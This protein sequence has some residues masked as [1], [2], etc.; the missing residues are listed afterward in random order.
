MNLTDEQWEVLEPPLLPEPPHQAD[1]RSGLSLRS[2]N[3]AL[4]KIMCLIVA[5]VVILALATDGAYAKAEAGQRGGGGGVR[6]VPSGGG[7][8]SSPSNR[9]SE[10]APSSAEAAK[11]SGPSNSYSAPPRDVGSRSNPYY[12]SPGYGIHHSSL[13]NF[14]LWSWIFHHDRDDPDYQYEYGGEPN[15]DVGGWLLSGLGAAGL[16]GL[17]W[18]WLRRRLT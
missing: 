7:K 16:A 4:G 3:I 6:G 10:S 8:P 2:C 5:A 17:G 11:P 12:G 9:P 13:S 14:L 1:G 18:W 15:E